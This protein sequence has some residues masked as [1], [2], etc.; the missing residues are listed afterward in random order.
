MH[1]EHLHIST[2]SRCVDCGVQVFDSAHL[3]KKGIVG[4]GAMRDAYATVRGSAIVKK[5]Q[6]KGDK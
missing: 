1:C 5:E 6:K 3:S 2:H 4:R